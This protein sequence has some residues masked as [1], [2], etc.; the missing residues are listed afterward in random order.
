MYE[1]VLSLCDPVLK[2][3]VCYHED[4]EDI[5]NKQD[6]LGL[7]QCIKKIMYSNGD[8]DT[9]M[10]YKHEVAI[11]NYYKVQQKSFQ[12]I[13]DYHNQFIAYRKLC[14]QL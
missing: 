3:Q 13:Q 9:H 14:G 4:T 10:G 11:T 5:N 2:D 8:D 1:V 7:L 6:T 12:S